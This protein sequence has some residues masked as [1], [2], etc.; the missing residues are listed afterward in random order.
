MLKTLS[1][2]SAKPRK[3]RV[4]I[5]GG[6]R[7]GHDGSEIDSGEVDDGK[8]EDDKVEKKV[9]KMSKSKNLSKSKKT[10]GFSDFLTFKAKLGFTKLRQVFFKTPIL[11]YFNPKHHIRIE[12][13]TSCY[14]IS[15]VF[16]QF[17]SDDL[18]RWH[19]TG[20]FS[21]KMIPA[22]TR[23]KTHDNELLAIV[24]VFMTW[25]HYLEGF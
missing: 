17:T 11:H 7:A 25:K 23:Y 2:K 1:T 8:V 12:I 21:Q 18:G 20:F 14:A 4:E 13:N 15:G 3:S 10:V 6:S 5:G 24:E 16:S 9:Q 22:K 19:P